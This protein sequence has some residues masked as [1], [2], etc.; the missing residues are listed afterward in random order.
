MATAP[1]KRK[2]VIDRV[3]AQLILEQYFDQAYSTT[4]APMMATVMGNRPP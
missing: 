1:R 2:Q 4:P 3:A